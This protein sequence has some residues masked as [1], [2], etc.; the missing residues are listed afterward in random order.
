VLVSQRT[1]ESAGERFEGCRPRDLELQGFRSPIRV[2]SVP[3][4]R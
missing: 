4:E 1:L 3:W 2:L